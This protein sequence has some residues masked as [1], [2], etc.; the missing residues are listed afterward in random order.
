MSTAQRLVRSASI[1]SWFILCWTISFRNVS[2]EAAGTQLRRPVQNSTTTMAT[3]DPAWS[4]APT[5]WQFFNS[6]VSQQQLRHLSSEVD[7]SA[8]LPPKCAC[9]PLGWEMVFDFSHPTCKSTNLP[10]HVK[11]GKPGLDMVSCREVPA[12]LE[13][14]HDDQLE[15]ASDVQI[16]EYNWQHV[17]MVVPHV[18]LAGEF[19][20]G[21][22]FGYHSIMGAQD[23]RTCTPDTCDMPMYIVFSFKAK[24]KRNQQEKEFEITWKFNHQCS[25]KPL[26][27]KGHFVGPLTVVRVC[28]CVCCRR[29]VV[30]ESCCCGRHEY[31]MLYGLTLLFLLLAPKFKTRHRLKPFLLPWHFVLRTN[32][33][34]EPS[35]LLY[36]Q[37]IEKEEEET[38][39]YGSMAR[40]IVERLYHPTSLGRTT[41]GI[42]SYISCCCV[43]GWTFCDTSNAFH[44]TPWPHIPA[45]D[46]LS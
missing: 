46:R 14:D 20:N 45:L 12:P 29:R 13:R 10:L 21:E 30:V 23:I 7:V 18:H 35:I 16:R 11:T 4:N 8:R 36:E 25:P 37:A 32:S 39:H 15:Y 24:T 17:Q 27:V 19:V 5:Q 28:A 1:A 38:Q 41:I 33:K 44:V 2:V 3:H 31:S 9:S 42:L 22:F 26:V 6:T 40:S 43:T 34:K